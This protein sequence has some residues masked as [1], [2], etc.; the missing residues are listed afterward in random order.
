M[1]RID[2]KLPDKSHWVKVFDPRDFTV[3]VERATDQPELDAD[4]RIDLTITDG[5]RVILRGKVIARRPEAQGNLGAGF[6]VALGAIEHEKINYLNGFVRG[7]LLDLR[8]RRRLPLRLRVAYGGLEGPC[9]SFTRDINEEGVFVIS[10]SPLPEG[11]E[12]HLLITLPE[13]GEPVSVS[14]IVSHT[15]V[16]E[17]ED[18]PGMGIQLRFEDGQA[19]P[20]RTLIDELEAKFAAG[21]LPE[22]VLL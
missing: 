11:S 15:V 12:V 22:E 4:V 13:R 10:D 17:D 8:E 9:E 6:T 3:F 20:F 18:V 7:G 14:G 19:E 21:S 16:V 1:V 5:P 2:L